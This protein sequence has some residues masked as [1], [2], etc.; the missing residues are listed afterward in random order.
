MPANLT[1]I[2]QNVDTERGK[3]RGN[4]IRPIT[5]TTPNLPVQSFPSPF[6]SPN[7]TVQKYH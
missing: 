5:L 7:P 6:L 1:I 3:K 4:V 2:Y